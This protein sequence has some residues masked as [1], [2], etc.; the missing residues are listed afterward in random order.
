MAAGAAKLITPMVTAGSGDRPLRV[1]YVSQDHLSHARAARDYGEMIA[2]R[3]EVVHD[4]ARADVAVLH[5][6]PH[7]VADLLKQHPAPLRCYRIGY[8]CWEADRLPAAYVPVMRLVH[9]VWTPSDYCVGV[10]AAHHGRVR[11]IPH[12]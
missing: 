6:E 8:F 12:V 2:T 10:F 9:E 4:P 5:V 7:L 11:K 3:H 1:L